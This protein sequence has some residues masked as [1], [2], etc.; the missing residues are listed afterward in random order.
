[1]RTL[2]ITLPTPEQNLALDEALLDLCE[3]GSGHEI[4]RLWEPL[5]YFVVL[6]YSNKTRLEINELSCEAD[7]LT[8]LRRISGG[9]TVLQGPGCLNYSLFLDLRK[10]PKLDGITSSNA[11][12]MEKNRV[13]LESLLGL[14]VRVQGH[15]DL[16]IENL[17]F[18]GNAQRRKKNYLLF[19]GTFL[20]R[21]DLDKIGKYLAMPEKRPAYR[22]ERAHRD[23]VMNIP[24][25]P[26]QIAQAVQKAWGSEGILDEIPLEKVAALVREKYSKEDWNRKF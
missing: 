19:H 14:P 2:D 25:K 9:G 21:F 17:K 13:A 1:M 16:T 8:V 24:V 11:H 18:S 15:T 6:G 5:E 7:G 12:I 23:F 4:L 22:A 3:E 20:Y 26:T 10:H